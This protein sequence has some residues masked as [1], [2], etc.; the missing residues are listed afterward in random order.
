LELFYSTVPLR[1]EWDKRVRLLAWICSMDDVVDNIDWKYS[2]VPLPLLCKEREKEGEAE[3]VQN[4]NNRWKLIADSSKFRFCLSKN[5][6]YINRI[7]L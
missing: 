5:Y 4:I 3:N 1:E 7:K 6:N 2:A